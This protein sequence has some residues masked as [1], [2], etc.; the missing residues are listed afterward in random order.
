MTTTIKVPSRQR[1]TLGRAVSWSL[2][3]WTCRPK[4]GGCDEKKYENKIFKIKTL[5]SVKPYF[6]NANPTQ[7]IVFTSSGQISK[8]GDMNVPCSGEFLKH[9]CHS[10]QQ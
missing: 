6:A 2:E 3:R 1:A 9:R 5:T 10:A 4:T 7:R 8:M